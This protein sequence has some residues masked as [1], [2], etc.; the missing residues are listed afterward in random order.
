M[1]ETSL[2][3]DSS[4][5]SGTEYYRSVWGRIVLVSLGQDIIDQSGEG[6]F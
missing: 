3:K 5:L 1:L 4:R 2:G 6:K